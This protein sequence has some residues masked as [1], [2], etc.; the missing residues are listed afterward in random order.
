MPD[1]FSDAVDSPLGWGE[2]TAEDVVMAKLR[3]H[4]AQESI[5]TK[6]RDRYHSNQKQTPPNPPPVQGKRRHVLVGLSA[7]LNHTAQRFFAHQ[8][9]L[10]E[11]S[12]LLNAGIRAEISSELF[13]FFQRLLDAFLL[14]SRSDVFRLHTQSQHRFVSRNKGE[15]GQCERQRDLTN[16]PVTRATGSRVEHH[17]LNHTRGRHFTHG[18]K[19]E[20]RRRQSLQI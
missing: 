5:C 10:V 16:I 13:E 20:K 4:P 18:E 19:E 17:H 14:F 2:C 11:I 3:S 1:E 7:V 9:H 15:F 8:D 6:C 12:F